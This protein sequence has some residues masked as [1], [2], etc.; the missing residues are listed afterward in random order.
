MTPLW[1]KAHA[2]YI[3]SYHSISADQITFFKDSLQN[4]MLLKVPLV[5]AGVLSDE[6]PLTI[7]MTVANDVSIAQSSDSDP[8]YG[9]SD[10]TSFVGFRTLDEYNYGTRAPCFGVQASSGAILTNQSSIQANRPIVRNVSFPDKFVFTLKLSRDDALGWC[11]TAQG[12]G[13]TKSAHYTTQLKLNRGL[14][15][16]VY[17][18]HKRETVGIKYMVVTIMNTNIND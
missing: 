11:F 6:T 8:N 15:V 16:E 12:G 13:F 9:V 18:K 5:A 17:K 3:D 10:G 2:S 1:L 14:T 7:E 4:A